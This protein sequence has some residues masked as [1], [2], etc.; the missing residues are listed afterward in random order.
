[1]I[2]FNIQYYLMSKTYRDYIQYYVAFVVVPQDDGCGGF[3][4]C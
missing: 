4:C 1:M 2:I 3:C